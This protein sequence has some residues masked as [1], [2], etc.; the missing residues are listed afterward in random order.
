MQSRRDKRRGFSL[1]EVLLAVAVIGLLAIPTF[2]ALSNA[3]SQEMRRVAR[4][5]MHE[6]ALNLLEE[7]LGV[8]DFTE[9]QGIYH[10]RFAFE[11]S[12]DDYPRPAQTRFDE[13]IRFTRLTVVVEIEGADFR[14][15][16]V[17][18]F[19]ARKVQQ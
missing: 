8:R 4:F 1:L 18:Q 17:S 10:D 13:L 11:V 14:P 6:F 3:A 2:T 9:E 12:V 19:V 7:R 5:Q 16:E 15:V